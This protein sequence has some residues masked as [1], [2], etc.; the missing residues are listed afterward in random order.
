MG[1]QP[2]R[3]GGSAGWL[4]DRAGVPAPP[5]AAQIRE[6]GRVTFNLDALELNQGSCGVPG[7]Q[8]KLVSWFPQR[9][10]RGCGHRH[11]IT[12]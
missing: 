8:A 4:A 1:R 7:E 12:I 3:L 9:L 11:L 2:H 5:P 10:D 6:V